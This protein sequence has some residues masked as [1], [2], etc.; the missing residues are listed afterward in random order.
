MSTRNSALE[1]LDDA[2]LDAASET[3]LSLGVRRTQV[4]EIA[5]RAGV[6]RPT[7]YRRWADSDA[8]VASLLTREILG[9][10]DAVPSTGDDRAALVRRVVGVAVR[11]R[12]HP[13]FGALV[14]HEPD[15]LMTYVLQR[16]GT[17]QRT[18]LTGLRT[19][20]ATAQAG[21]TVRPGNPDQLATTVLLIAQSMIQSHRM[22]TDVLP[23]RVWRRELAHAVDGYLAP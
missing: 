4:S 7:V 22:V 1:A 11:L 14:D 17:S 2:I 20:I 10:V 9:A 21:G 6:S 18:V 5:R 3:V 23:P 16:L 13:L 8:I 15:V 19:A 12:E